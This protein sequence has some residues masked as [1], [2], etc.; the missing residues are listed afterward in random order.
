MR[1]HQIEYVC[2]DSW[3]QGNLIYFYL[4]KEWHF[5]FSQ[6]KGIR[7]GQF[8]GWLSGFLFT[9]GRKVATATLRAEPSGQRLPFSHLFFSKTRLTLIS[10]WP[11]LDHVTTSPYLSLART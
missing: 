7:S 3:L 1:I 5:F 4:N 6:I 11:E 2:C 8:Q 10:H 9:Y